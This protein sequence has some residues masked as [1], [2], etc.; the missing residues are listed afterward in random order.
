MRVIHPIN[1]IWN[2]IILEF[3]LHWTPHWILF[4]TSYNKQ[5]VYVSH[6]SMQTNFKCGKSTI[7]TNRFS[8][9]FIWFRKRILFQSFSLCCYVHK[10]WMANKQTAK[11][12]TFNDSRKKLRQRNLNISCSC[13]WIFSCRAQCCRC[14]CWS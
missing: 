2:H 10:S 12:T 3:A 4:C 6:T 8:I 13:K 7:W 14:C 1:V 5:C 9:R 11:L